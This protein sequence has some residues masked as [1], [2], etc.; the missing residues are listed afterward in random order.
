MLFVG[1]DDP[2]PFQSA[3]ITHPSFINITVLSHPY[4]TRISYSSQHVVFKLFSKFQHFY[5]FKVA[6]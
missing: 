1:Y 5:D 4:G 6:M 2:H 3:G